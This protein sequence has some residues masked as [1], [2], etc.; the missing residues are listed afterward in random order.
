RTVPALLEG[1][2]ALR[3]NHGHRSRPL[4]RGE[5]CLRRPENPRPPLEHRQGAAPA[6]DSIGHVFQRGGTRRAGGLGS[7]GTLQNIGTTV[8]IPQWLLVQREWA[9][10]WHANTSWP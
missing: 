10:S 2:V 8:T 5:K 1:T 4:R 6:S 3:A 7:R 9:D